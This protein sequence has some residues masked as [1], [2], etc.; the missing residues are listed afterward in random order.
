MNNKVDFEAVAQE[1]LKEHGKYDFRSLDIEL[2]LEASGYRIFPVAGLAEIAEAFISSLVQYIFIDEDQYMG[3]GSF[4][5]RFTLA[6]E[7]AH[8]LL[9]RPLF[10]GKSHTEIVSYQEKITDAE[11]KS[12]E[13]GAKNLA[14]AL[15]M[16]A[17]LFDPRFNHFWGLQRPKVQSDLVALRY[18]F[19]QLNFDFN[20][21]VH[22][23]AVRA[24]VRGLI[25][26]EQLE[27]YL[28]PLMPRG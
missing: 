9:H 25:D 3:V 1:W 6:E 14:G 4:R 23:V 2:S 19:R 11:Y 26:E 5:G 27:D 24:R 10:R 22:A 21:S 12:I 28:E 20:V 16:P 7:L 18:V 13:R 17:H 8:D 15:L